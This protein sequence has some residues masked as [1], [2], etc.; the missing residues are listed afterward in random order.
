MKDDNMET[1]MKTVVNSIMSKTINSPDEIIYQ[2]K[3][4]EL[5]HYE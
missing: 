4:K 2:I 5:N 3:L 1:M